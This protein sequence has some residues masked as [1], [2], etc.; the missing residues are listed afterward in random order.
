MLWGSLL[1]QS[2]TRGGGVRFRTWLLAAAFVSVCT[3]GAGHAEETESQR[4]RSFLDRAYESVVRRS[5]MLAAAKSQF[6]YDRLDA[7]AKLQYR[8]FVNK[9]QLLLHCYRWRD[10][11][12]PRNQ[13]VGLHVAVSDVL[14][15]QQ[16][17]DNISYLEENS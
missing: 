3:P 6:S 11:L 16:R 15:N 2:R 8:G 5:P 17:L 14:I 12:Y 13:I 9:S 1:S 10:E 7:S 4:F